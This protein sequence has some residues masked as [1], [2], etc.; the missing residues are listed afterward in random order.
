M[1]FIYN[2]LKKAEH[3]GKVDSTWFPQTVP[4]KRQLPLLLTVPQEV[5]K[6]FSMLT[7]NVR[8]A[9]AEHG[10]QIIGIT[11]SVSG[12]G[13]ST[14]AYY[15]SLMLAQS[16]VSNFLIENDHS[17]N[18]THRKRRNG[19]LLIDGNLKHPVLHQLFDVNPNPG[20][21]EFIMKARSRNIVMKTIS[22]N[23]LNL[24]TVGNNNGLY[25]DVWHS[26]K[27]KRIMTGFRDQ[28]EYI[29][30]DAPPV[31]GNPETLVL[32]RL[33]DGLL[34][35]IK[36]N[37]TRWEIIEEAKQQLRQAGLKILGAVLN[38]R[39]YFIPEII[40]KSLI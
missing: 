7:M 5:V 27:I 40:Y 22:A 36:A 6:T 20:L 30:I 15:L 21:A 24:I 16:I 26:N 32:G 10:P 33:T 12:E 19:V 38:E 23:Y 18:G 31:I 1:D 35:V 8:Q 25:H 37:H 9:H 34:F 13:R 28:F 2:A 29:L 39:Q 17:G 3:E 11:S 4:K 14:I